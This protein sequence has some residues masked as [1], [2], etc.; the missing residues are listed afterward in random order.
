MGYRDGVA[1]LKFGF[2]FVPTVHSRHLAVNVEHLDK[3]EREISFTLCGNKELERSRVITKQTIVEEEQ[4]LLKEKTSAEC[5]TE[6]ENLPNWIIIQAH[7][8]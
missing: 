6:K 4:P 5:D 1:P 7:R 3:R 8:G 2:E